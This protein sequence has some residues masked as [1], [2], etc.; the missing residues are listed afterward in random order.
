MRWGCRGRRGSSVSEWPNMG[1]PHVKTSPR[2]MP[3][4]WSRWRLPNRLQHVTTL[5]VPRG[6]RSR[7]PA[8]PRTDEAGVA[9]APDSR[10]DWHRIAYNALVSRA[11]DDTEETTN[12]NKATVPREN[13][14]LYQ[15]SARGH[16]VA[17]VILGS[18]INH[19]H[20]A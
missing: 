18:L 4:G 8:K 20:D 12:K 17:E 5:P 19:R 6:P 10:F 7:G 13:L 2:T 16:E 3:D 11:L 15:F 9:N 14:V 1:Y